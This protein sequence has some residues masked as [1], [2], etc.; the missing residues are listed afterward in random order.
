MILILTC[1]H[2][3]NLIPQEYQDLFEGAEKTLASHRGYDLGAL[4]LFTELIP[5]SDYSYSHEIS[6]LLVELNRSLHHPQLFSAY[7]KGLSSSKQQQLLEQYYLP[8]RNAVEKRIA[9]I[10]KDG[11]EVLHLA[12]HSFTR[13]LKGEVRAT[14]IGLLYDPSRFGEK[15]ACRELKNQLKIINPNLKTRSNYPYLGKADGFP[16]YL[17]KLFPTGYYGIELEVNQKFVSDNNQM[18]V[19]IKKDIF[20]AVKELKESF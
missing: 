5:L 7:T 10:L 14:D 18:A 6:R 3:G 11:R 16:T 8:Y 19:F 12:V 20:L 4:D 2:G 1:E 15:R 9:G 17:R 13:E